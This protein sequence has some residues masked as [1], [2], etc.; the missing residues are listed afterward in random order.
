MF[1]A[2]SIYL[3]SMASWAEPKNNLSHKD[4]ILGDNILEVTTYREGYI[5]YR[6]ILSRDDIYP[7]VNIEY[8]ER[9]GEGSPPALHASINVVPGKNKIS[10]L[11]V[12]NLKWSNDT[13]SFSWGEQF[14][15][16]KIDKKLRGKITA[17]PTCL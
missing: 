16:Y 4:M 10:D 2:L 3:F 8:F 6:A 17:N 11:Q 12:S 7:S 15:S 13:L 5:N 9:G 1:M 14:C